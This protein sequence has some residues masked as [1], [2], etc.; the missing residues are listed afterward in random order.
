MIP[1]I[2]LS[3]ALAVAVLVATFAVLST[4]RDGR[5]RERDLER[6]LERE[7][8]DKIDVLDRVMYATGKPWK[9]TADRPDSSSSQRE[10]DEPPIVEDPV[11]G[12]DYGGAFMSELD[13]D[14]LEEQLSDLH[15]P[16]LVDTRNVDAL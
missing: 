7:R 3:A 8:R 2:A 6:A 4:I 13:F 15:E 1:V 5:R 14:I 10:T 12:A 11:A 16:M 9:E